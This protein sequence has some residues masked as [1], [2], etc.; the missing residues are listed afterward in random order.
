MKI[1]FLLHN[2]YAIGGTERTTLNLAAPLAG[3][4][5][6]EVEIVSMSRHREVPRFTVDPAV[7]LVPLVG[8]RIGSADPQYAAYEEPARDFPAA[9]KRHKQY[10]RLHDLRVREYLERCDADVVIGTRPGINV[11]LAMYGP[12]SAL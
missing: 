4:G 8:T 3:R 5:G 7:S 11:Y 1:V 10:T 12:R 9:E 2:A 6:H